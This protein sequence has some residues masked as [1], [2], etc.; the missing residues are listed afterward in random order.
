MAM[1]VISE[2]RQ[3]RRARLTTLIAIQ[4]RRSADARSVASPKEY[5]VF[6]SVTAD[7][8]PHAAGCSLAYPL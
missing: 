1:R 6:A 2:A 4:N 8:W 3:T 5:T 7:G